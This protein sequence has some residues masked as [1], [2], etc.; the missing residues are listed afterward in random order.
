M[1]LN[2]KTSCLSLEAATLISRY[3]NSYPREK[4]TSEVA[5]YVEERR[6]SDRASGPA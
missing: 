6:F 5:Y 4:K 3:C 1:D 2:F